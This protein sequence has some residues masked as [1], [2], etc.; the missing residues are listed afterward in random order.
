MVIIFIHSV[1]KFYT[2]G[3]VRVPVN[4]TI[5]LHTPHRGFD[6]ETEFE[7]IARYGSWHPAR[8]KL[9]TTDGQYRIE[10]TAEELRQFFAA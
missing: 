2:A 7:Q 5:T 4:R 1:V 10:V 9:E 6:A 8:A 3:T